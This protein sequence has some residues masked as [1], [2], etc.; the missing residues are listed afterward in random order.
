M[1]TIFFIIGLVGI[2]S[3]SA[4]GAMV[5]I[6]RETDLF[7]V[8][9]LSCV[10]CFG[11]GLTRDLILGDGLPALFDMTLELSISVATAFV[12]FFAAFIFKKEYVAEEETVNKINNVLDALGIGIFA[13]VGASM[14]IELGPLASIFAGTVS[15][16]G[17]SLIRDVILRDVPF[18]LRKRVYAVAV[19][20]GASLYYVFESYVFVNVANSNVFST[21]ICTVVVFGIRMCATNFDW[22]LPKAIRFDLMRSESERDAA[23][24]ADETVKK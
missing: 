22:N 16:V 14:Y 11:G 1:E 19:L 24:E 9:I 17:G 2:I 6:D 12:I 5:A 7:G 10:T 8:I 3:F 15:S 4:S 20:I 21:I 13:A 18:I 23:D